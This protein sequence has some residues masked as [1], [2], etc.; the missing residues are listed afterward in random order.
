MKAYGIDKNP[1]G[2]L[3]SKSNLQRYT[4]QE[5]L[6]NNLKKQITKPS[7][8]KYTFRGMKTKTMERNPDKVTTKK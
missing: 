8:S 4:P 6:A 7:E 1:Q 2:S 3:N 5:R